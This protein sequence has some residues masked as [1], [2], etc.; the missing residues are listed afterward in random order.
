MRKVRSHTFKLGKY[1]IEFTHGI[2]GVTDMPDGYDDDDKYHMIILEG[3]S[4]RALHSAIHEAMHA[5]GIPSKYIHDKD[6]CA[7]ER[8]ARFL[9]RLG[10]RK[11]FPQSR[12]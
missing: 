3:K 11:K 2:E 9:W 6:G 8:I 1:V 4:F 7:T 12:G 10:W 5:E